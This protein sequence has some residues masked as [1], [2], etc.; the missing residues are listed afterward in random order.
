MDLGQFNVDSIG[1][2]RQGIEV[3]E[4]NYI[5]KVAKFLKNC[6]GDLGFNNANFTKAYA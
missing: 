3:I 1:T 6:N 4:V 5:K 2:I